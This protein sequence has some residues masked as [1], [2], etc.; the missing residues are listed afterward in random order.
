VTGKMTHA[1]EVPSVQYVDTPDGARLAYMVGGEGATVVQAPFHYN[2]VLR[3]WSGPLWARGVAEHFR[4][5]IYDSR[6]QGLSTRD[7]PGELS[8]RDYRTDL[9]A[10]IDVTGQERFALIG[11]GGFGQVAARYAAEHPERVTA[12]ILI[13]SSE[14][15]DAWSP[16]AHLGIAEENWDLFLDLQTQKLPPE[17]RRTMR[18]F[19]SDSTG[20]SDYLKMMRA[21]VSGPGIGDILPKLSVPTLLLHS[22][23]QHWLPPAEGAKVASKIAGARILFTDGDVEPDQDQAVPAIIDFLRGVYSTDAI[24]PQPRGKA[25]SGEPLTTRQTEVLVLISRGRT[26]REIAAE[27]TLS[28]RTVERHVADLYTKIGA[29]NRS[30]ATAFYLSRFATQSPE[31]AE[32]TQSH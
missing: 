11:Y 22:L 13:C 31:L 10:I 12:L 25:P 7:L 17:W 24:G 23:D 28:E 27:L 14:S 3:R 5:A 6:G 29:R 15:F 9:E 8:V 21:F 18:G 16:S 19:L 26:T 32:S 1:T 4:V 30:E 20:Q 2:H